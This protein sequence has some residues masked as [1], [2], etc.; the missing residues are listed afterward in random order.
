MARVILS[1]RALDDLERL[2][3]THGLPPTWEP[4][5][6]SLG[7]LSAFPRLGPR[8]HGRWEGYRFVLGPWRWMIVV[9]HVDDAADVVGVIAIQDARMARAATTE[10]RSSGANL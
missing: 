2:I 5:R 3:T 6:Q 4:V 7:S 8:L 10:R 1:P 9:Y